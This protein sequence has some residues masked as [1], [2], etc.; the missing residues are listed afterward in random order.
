[1]EIVTSWEQRGI[2]AGRVEALRAA[3]IEVLDWRFGNLDE[4]LA[5]RLAAIDCVDRLRTL[6]HQAITAGSI[7]ELGF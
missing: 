3:L 4:S 2:E 6:T 7:Q 1:V 5:V